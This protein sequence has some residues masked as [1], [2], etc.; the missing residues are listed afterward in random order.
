[1]R[2]NKSGEEE[3]VYAYADI[4][5]NN[6]TNGDKRKKK[7]Y[8]DKK[9]NDSSNENNGVNDYPTLRAKNSTILNDYFEEKVEEDP[10]FKK[11]K[12]KIEKD[13][14]ISFPVNK[15]YSINLFE[16][17]LVQNKH[18]V[19]LTKP[20]FYSIFVENN[21]NAKW[22][23]MY[24]GLSKIQVELSYKLM[25]KSLS[26]EEFDIREEWQ[27]EEEMRKE[28]KEKFKEERGEE[29]GEE[30]DSENDKEEG[31]E[32]KKKKDEQENTEE[33]DEMTDI[34]LLKEVDEV[35]KFNLEQTEIKVKEDTEKKKNELGNSYKVKNTNYY[36]NLM[37]KRKHGS[38]I[39]DSDTFQT[40]SYTCSFYTENQIRVPSKKKKNVY[41]YNKNEKTI[42]EIS[43]TTC[44]SL[45]M[46]ITCKYGLL[47]CGKYNKIPDDP[48]I[49]FKKSVSILSLDG[50]GVLSISTLQILS[51]LETEIRKEIG[52]D[53]INLIDCFDMISGTSAGGLI[54]LALLREI[55]V[56]DM[57]KFWPNTIKK[58]F[59]GKR[60][61]ISGIL[62]EGYDINKVKNVLIDNIGNKFISSYKKLYCF[63]TTTDVKHKPYKL[64]L[65]RNYTHKYKSIN[66]ES[67]DGVDKV[68]L[69]FAAWATSSAPTY[70][71]GPSTEDIERLGLKINPEIH[72]V[73]G[74]L[75]ANNPSL[76]ALEEC[77]RLNNKSLSVFIKEDLD[78]L[79]SVGTGQLPTKLTQS[80]NSGKSA[81]TFDILIN[82]THL[83]TR[84][85]DTHR[86]VLQWLADRENTYFR[87][88]APNI[89]EIELDS[90]D[91]K[92]FDLIVKATQDYLFDEKYYEI[93][94]LAHK[95][96]NNY[97]RSKYL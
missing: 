89:G 48:Y 72:L 57:V 41:F 24:F 5:V 28:E 21:N 82:S 10:S 94:R 40:D 74:A 56:Q 14:A 55:S 50:G 36:D 75:K 33:Q 1:M 58:I 30:S 85:N 60:N 90:Q 35:C 68:P 20:G 26:M 66:G 46:S 81:S 51:R 18:I 47:Y 97:I 87:F 4:F 92:D 31:G 71:K 43:A 39:F 70:L 69:W 61:I 9:R 44:M 2:N 62:F 86:E 34:N 54:S 32:E 53:E 76:I 93:K 59:E 6:Y 91:I 17:E 52:N 12:E 64:F 78:T 19:R 95:L 16:G 37:L 7:S 3:K 38:V 42:L 45:G 25:L 83:L 8:K 79:V 65:I 22:D 96:A 80:A 13:S 73:D 49:P 15:N 84:A 77:A 27:N 11:G 88:N 63:V 29:G 23:S 67:Y